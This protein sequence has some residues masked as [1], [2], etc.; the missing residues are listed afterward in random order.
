MKIILTTGIGRTEKENVPEPLAKRLKQPYQIFKWQ[1]IIENDADQL[2]RIHT[3]Y[4]SKL[5]RYLRAKMYDYGYDE[6]SYQKHKHEIMCRLENMIKS[7]PGDDDII[8]IGHSW[9]CVIF[10]DYLNSHS[11][12]RVK[13]LITFG[14]P[15]PFVK[16]QS[17][18][19]FSGID[20]VN[21]YEPSDP[22]A[23][24]ML[25]TTIKDVKFTNRTLKGMLPLAH[26]AYFKSKK[27]AKW[28]RKELE[29]I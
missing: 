28:I 29:I 21:Y 6:T 3:R 4:G 20:W 27:L 19:G 17:Y 13:K 23:H 25:R 10:Y 15:I 11:L 16:G 24:K 8:L 12:S 2:I 5:A 18:Y 9:G 7:T 22:V 14:N 26:I 1:D